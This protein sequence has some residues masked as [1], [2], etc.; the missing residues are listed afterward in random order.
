MFSQ[1]QIINR[2]LRLLYILIQVTNYQKRLPPTL[3]MGCSAF[4]HVALRGQMKEVLEKYYHIDTLEA[5]VIAPEFAAVTKTVMVRMFFFFPEYEICHD[6]Q[7]A[8]ISC[9]FKETDLQS[10]GSWRCRLLVKVTVQKE[11]T[12]GHVQQHGHGS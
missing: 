8:M 3:T 9:F 5:E 12:A 2:N 6:I 1:S 7:L 10:V 11:N 4:F